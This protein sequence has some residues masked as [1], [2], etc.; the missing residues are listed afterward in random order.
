MEGLATDPGGEETATIRH[1]IF[2]HNQPR[3]LSDIV[4]P[5]RLYDHDQRKLTSPIIYTLGTRDAD[6]GLSVNLEISTPTS[7]QGKTK[8]K[9]VDGAEVAYSMKSLRSTGKCD[10]RLPITATEASIYVFSATS[11]YTIVFV[12]VYRKDGLYIPD[13]EEIGIRDSDVFEGGLLFG[14]LKAK[15]RKNTDIGFVR[16][17]RVALPS[18]MSLENAIQRLE[19]REPQG[20][21]P[22]KSVL[23]SESHYQG[24]SDGN[25]GNAD[26]VI[27]ISDDEADNYDGVSTTDLDAEEAGGTEHLA[28]R[29][30]SRSPG[31]RDSRSESVRGA[32]D[33]FVTMLRTNSAKPKRHRHDAHA[34]TKGASTPAPASPEDGQ[35]GT[36]SSTSLFRKGAKHVR[37]GLEKLY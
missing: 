26:A 17:A 34:C 7:A 25:R 20:K 4:M 6:I 33:N 1:D 32:F 5:L 13:L 22:K 15:F 8:M 23:H 24:P 9:T 10:I 3:K 37:Q 28:L 27:E 19:T 36:Q 29:K 30:R 21:V 14:Q 2:V 16:S 18:T 11:G 12:I 31:G 35:M